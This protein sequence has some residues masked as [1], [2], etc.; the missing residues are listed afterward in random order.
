MFVFTA[1]LNRKKA[2]LITAGLAVVLALI[3]LAVH[4]ASSG[5]RTGTDPSESGINGT[6]DIVAYLAA[7]GW[8]VDPEPIETQSIVIPRRFSG[9]YADYVRLQKEQGY[10]IEDYAGIQ[11]ARHSFR[12][13]NYPTGEK[14]IV[15]DVVLFGRQIIA[16]DIQSTASDGFMRALKSPASPSV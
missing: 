13:T 12:V 4:A 10:P 1:K 8:K 3:V 2:V 11:A 5:K 16:G 15:A 9:V 7:F 14:D 6:E